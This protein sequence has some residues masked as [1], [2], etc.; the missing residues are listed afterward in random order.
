V[1]L[2][3]GEFS[4]VPEG[5]GGFKAVVGV[6][7]GGSGGQAGLVRWP[8]GCGVDFCCKWL[9][10]WWLHS[11][12]FGGSEA[13]KGFASLFNLWGKVLMGFGKVLKFLPLRMECK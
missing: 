12:D 1:I 4:N 5:G 10:G 8:N 13:A 11:A 9:I 3:G 7:V 6:D 2:A